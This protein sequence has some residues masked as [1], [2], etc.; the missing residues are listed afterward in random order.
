MTVINSSKQKP[1]KNMTSIPIYICSDPLIH[2]SLRRHLL[3]ITRIK[4][5]VPG[6]FLH[7]SW[8]ADGLKRQNGENNFTAE[9]IPHSGLFYYCYRN[10]PEFNFFLSSVS[11]VEKRDVSLAVIRKVLWGEKDG[12]N[13]A[14]IFNFNMILT[15]MFSLSRNRLKSFNFLPSL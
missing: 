1:R 15:F 4:W 14:I 2:K 7:H 8:F 6:I 3:F 13:I 9:G 12:K 11:D 5:P 10:K